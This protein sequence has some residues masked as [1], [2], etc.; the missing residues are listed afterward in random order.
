MNTGTERPLLL[1]AQ[2][3]AI[4][5]REARAAAEPYPRD[6]VGYH[7]SISEPGSCAIGLLN[8]SMEVGSMRLR[9][10]M[11]SLPS[12]A[13]VSPDWPCK[14]E[15]HWARFCLPLAMNPQTR[16]RGCDS[17]SRSPVW[18]LKSILGARLACLVVMLVIACAPSVAQAAPSAMEAARVQYDMGLKHS[19]AGEI[20]LALAAFQRAYGLNPHYAVLFNIGQLQ[21][22]LGQPVQAE[23]SLERYLRDGGTAVD[24]QR[25]ERA[26]KSIEACRRLIGTLEIEVVPPGAKIL[27]DGVDV[28]VGS[29]GIR[30][31]SGHHVVVASRDGYESAVLTSLVKPGQVA[32]IQ[33]RLIRTGSSVG[34]VSLACEVPDTKLQIDGQRVS[35][36]W[37]VPVPL[38]AGPHQMRFTR[39]GY[40]PSTQTIEISEGNVSTLSCALAPLS[41]LPP[42]TAGRLVVEP[43]PPGARATLDGT[44][45]LNGSRVPAGA[46]DVRVS[47]DGYLPWHRRVVISPNTESRIFLD[48]SP[49]PAK[50][51]ELLRAAR[52]TRTLAY[53]TGGAGV[54]LAGAAVATFVV[55]S[56]QHDDWLKQRDALSAAPNLDRRSEYG[57]LA[58]EAATIQ[59]LDDLALA[60][61]L[62]GGTLI[63]TSAYLF[64]TG[65]DPALYLTPKIKRSGGLTGSSWRW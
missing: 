51:H 54:A 55:A 16:R 30:V 33:A 31:N 3:H 20:D 37:A 52:Q 39:R 42:A 45:F 22:A 27:L 14:G 25:T 28:A 53:V 24:N 23:A 5:S 26:L 12:I 64:L 59:R 9:T 49:T 44:A 58:G 2:A 10:P 15:S 61:A 1:G 41:P 36:S 63:A 56:R 8:S 4:A 48:I 40:V 57:E 50:R 7:R 13:M 21:L 32:R 19:E 17:I 60:A 47:V 38:A 35:A 62:A 29:G 43:L 65:E 6:D 11:H 46:H 34:W 18:G